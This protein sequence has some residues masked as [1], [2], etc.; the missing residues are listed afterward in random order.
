MSD[1]SRELECA[2]NALKRIG[3]SDEEIEKGEAMAL[4]AKT[5][6]KVSALHA[7]G[8]TDE[9]MSAALRMSARQV[10]YWREMLHLPKN[11]D[12]YKA[13][14]K[15]DCIYHTDAV[16]PCDYAGRTGHTR[17]AQIPR[18][19]WGV[20]PC[21]LY[22]SSGRMRDGRK[23]PTSGIDWDHARELWEQGMTDRQ[24]A[25]SMNISPGGVYAHRREW[26]AGNKS[27][28]YDWEYARKL[29]EQG[30]SDR[31]IAEELGCGLKSA[32]R[33]RREW[34][35]AN[36]G[37]DWDL[38]RRM[39]TEGKSQNEIAE[40]IGCSRGSVCKQC[41]AWREEKGDE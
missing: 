32:Q 14:P 30:A 13:C 4:R 38:A 16:N 24:I 20:Y 17:L 10:R 28:T 1:Y 37:I 41:R 7:K 34:G 35:K 12:V 8:M 15:K 5:L 36:S 27:N 2:V 31:Q 39:W 6:D 40:T 9:K 18:E 11:R 33:K 21:R 23:K 22:V 3:L 29:W 26:G 25:E 19:E